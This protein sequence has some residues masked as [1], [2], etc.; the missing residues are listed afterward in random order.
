MTKEQ[1]TELS[2]DRIG[3]SFIKNVSKKDIL[4]KYDGED[5][6]IYAGEEKPMANYLAVLLKEHYPKEIVF[7]G[8][9]EV[10]EEVVIPEIPQDKTIAQVMADERVKQ[11]EIEKEELLKK[12]SEK[13][14]KEVKKVKKVKTAQK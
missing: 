12:L 3:V 13:E 14:I 10:K 9:E 7:K 6:G 11:L 1:L 2:K 5:Y 4:H 8:D